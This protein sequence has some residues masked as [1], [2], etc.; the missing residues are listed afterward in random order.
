MSNN[1]NIIKYQCKL[2]LG[3]YNFKKEILKDGKFPVNLPIYVNITGSIEDVPVGVAKVTKASENCLQIEANIT[4][5]EIMHAVANAKNYGLDYKFS[6]ASECAIDKDSI[7]EM[8]LSKIEL[9]LT[10][11]S[12]DEMVS[13]KERIKQRKLEYQKKRNYWW[14]RK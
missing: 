11:A 7:T 2:S 13:E 12:P 3:N 5:Q 1:K 8:K 4:D 14:K 10:E 9:S 6:I